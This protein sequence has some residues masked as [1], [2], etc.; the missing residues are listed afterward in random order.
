[1]KAAINRSHNEL[2]GDIQILFDYLFI[3]KKWW[4]N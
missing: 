2:H 1:M 3:L 4:R